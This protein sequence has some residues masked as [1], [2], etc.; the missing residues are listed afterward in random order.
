MKLCSLEECDALISLIDSKLEPLKAKACKGPLQDM[1]Y[2]Y[3]KVYQG[4][5]DDLLSV[6]KT[7]EKKRQ[8]QLS[9]AIENTDLLKK[10][11]R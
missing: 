8:I 1:E 2:A 3:I 10:R 7:V 6:K 4:F 11:V 5:V 9:E